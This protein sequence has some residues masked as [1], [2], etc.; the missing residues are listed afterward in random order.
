MLN[1]LVFFALVSVVLFVASN[2]NPFD[3]KPSQVHIALA[4]VDANGNPNGMSISYHTNVATSSS[5]VKYG[6]SSRRYSNTIQ[7]S[8]L[9]YYETFHHHVVLGNLQ[10]STMFY[11]VVGN[12]LDGWSKEFTFKSAPTSES[13]RGNYTFAYFA[14][15]GSV[16]GEWTVKHMESI[17]DSVQ[18]IL[19]GGDVGYADDSF[20]HMRCAL[21]FCYE[22]AYNTY[23]N[24][25]ERFFNQK[26]MF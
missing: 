22:K 10:P 1:M 24:G 21:K 3:T 11:Y 17:K 26:L 20:L 15:L 4:G 9:S 8:Q 25:W 13:L 5:S 6:V 14:D 18:L 23:M 12:D 16:N 2:G 7:G 19:H